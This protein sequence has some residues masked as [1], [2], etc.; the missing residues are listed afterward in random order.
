ME[1]ATMLVMCRQLPLW[2]F[3]PMSS[4]NVQAE[5]VPKAGQRGAGGYLPTG[6]ALDDK[7]PAHRGQIQWAGTEHTQEINGH[8]FEGL[9]SPK[10][11]GAKKY[12]CNIYAHTRE[13]CE[14]KLKQF[15]VEM[16]TEIAGAKWLRDRGKGDGQPM[17]GKKG[18]RAKRWK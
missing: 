12:T 17:E 2:I 18:K 13:G 9:Y 8:L 7:L 5:V 4:G 14:E 11:P 10:W 16:R 1:A 6:V 15:I 3:T